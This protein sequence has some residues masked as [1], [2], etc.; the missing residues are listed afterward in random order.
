[1]LFGNSMQ[2]ERFFT[3][4]THTEEFDRAIEV[5]EAAFRAVDHPYE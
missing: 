2:G 3:T 4:Y 5:A 1:M